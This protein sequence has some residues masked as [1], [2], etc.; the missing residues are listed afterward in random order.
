MGIPCSLEDIPGICHQ[1]Y[2]VE[3]IEPSKSSITLSQWPSVHHWKIQAISAS[4]E[5]PSQRYAI[6]TQSMCA[7]YLSILPMDWNSVSL[8]ELSNLFL[9]KKFVSMS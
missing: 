4:S 7:P 6:P 3:T 9:I 1:K 2:S 5:R 8:L